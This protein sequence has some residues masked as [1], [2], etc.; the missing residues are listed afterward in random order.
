MCT[1]QHFAVTSSV[2]P[3]HAEIVCC[4]DM[5]RRVSA[6]PDPEAA[7]EAVAAARERQAEVAARVAALPAPAEE[8]PSTSAGVHGASLHGT[9][10]CSEQEA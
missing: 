6:A 1:P 3:A 2:R 7:A 5:R 8:G 9:C 10:I 4:T